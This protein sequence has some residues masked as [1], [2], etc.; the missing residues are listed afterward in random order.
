MPR[1]KQFNKEEVIG[2]AMKLFWEKGY[3]ATSLTDLTVALGIGKG[4]FYD[5]FGSKK[6]LFNQALKSYQSMGLTTLD[7]ILSSSLDPVEGIAAFLDTHTEFML[8]DPIA[9]GCFFANTTSEC[10]NDESINELLLD[11]NKKMK[12]RLSD[13]LEDETDDT[14]VVALVDVIIT[15]VTGI[16]IMSKVVKDP[17]R[18]ESSNKLFMVLIE[19]TLKK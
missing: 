4:S 3:E 10:S 19:D 8:S 6:E 12:L 17:A 14:D 18:F 1:V 5:T 16:S 13:Y 15:H 11:H 7:G 9:K 2:K